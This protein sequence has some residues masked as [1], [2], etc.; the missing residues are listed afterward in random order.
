MADL[1]N[2]LLQSAIVSYLKLQAVVLAELSSTLEIREDQWQ[3]INFVYPCIR[4]QMNA[5]RP[6]AYCNMSDIEFSVLAY[7]EQA[8]SA[9]ADKIAGIIKSVLHA[10]SFSQSGYNFSLRCTD[11]VPADRDDERT[12]LSRVRLAGAVSG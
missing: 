6:F 4:V 11:L 12:W 7:S 9:Q 1:R 3:G 2:D 10:K 8:S 5:N